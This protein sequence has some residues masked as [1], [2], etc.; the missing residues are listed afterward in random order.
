MHAVERELIKVTGYKAQRKFSDRQDYLKS[1]LN[2][3]SKLENDDFD[4]LTDAAAS[5]TNAA[6]E[7]TNSRVDDIPDFD[8]VPV[9]DAEGNP[10][11]DSSAD[12]TTDPP[13]EPEDDEPSDDDESDEEDEPLQAAEDTDE[14]EAE[15]VPDKKPAK[16]LAKAKKEVKKE[17]KAP[18]PAA[19][20][21][22]EYEHEVEMDRW[23]CM[24]GSKAS[25]AA[26]MFERGA[27]MKEVTTEIVGTY[28]NLLKKLV[29]HGHVL[30]KE[31]HVLKICHMDDLEG[32]NV[33]PKKKKK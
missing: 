25:Y 6:V 5:W 8:E 27:T 2:A 21:K 18:G 20:P 31:G 29:K 23:G 14:A 30:E 4:G 1:I 33:A 11:E 13:N 19:K 17:V 15:V 22:F 28:Y 32:K 16:K 10:S 9:T 26:A 24:I 12:D 7:S 3:V